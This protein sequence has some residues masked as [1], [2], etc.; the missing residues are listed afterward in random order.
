MYVLLYG[1]HY[2]YVLH[3]IC[4]ILCVVFMCPNGTIALYNLAGVTRYKKTLRLLMQDNQLKSLV[5]ISII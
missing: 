2:F 5:R 3:L 1:M 4:A